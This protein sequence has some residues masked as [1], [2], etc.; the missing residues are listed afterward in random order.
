MLFCNDKDTLANMH[1][2]EVRIC[3]SQYLQNYIK[4]FVDFNNDSTLIKV[5]ICRFQCLQNYLKVFVDFNNDKIKL[6][7]VDF[8]TNKIKN[9]ETN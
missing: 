7:F 6:I 5:R 4:V 1:Y 2:I 3:R 9:I 8:S